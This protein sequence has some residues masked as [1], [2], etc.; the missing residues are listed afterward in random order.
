VRVSVDYAGY[1]GDETP[2]RIRFGP[3]LVEIIEALDRWFAPDHRYFKVRAVDGI[4]ILQNDVTSGEWKMTC[5]S[6]SR[7]RSDA[8]AHRCVGAIVPSF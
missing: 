4:R 3:R 6:A 7:M 5:S 1:R 8:E 2:L